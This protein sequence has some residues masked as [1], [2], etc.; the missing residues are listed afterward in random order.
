MLFGFVLV[1]FLWGT[2]TPFMRRSLLSKDKQ[3]SSASC[4][5]PWSLW[6]RLAALAT[7]W[8]FVVPYA[9][10]QCG[11]VLFYYLL[12]G[13]DMCLAVPAANTLSFLFTFLTEAAQR[14][15]KLNIRTH[16]NT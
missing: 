6:L 3:M 1:G 14:K 2:T 12:T 10:N 4:S 8:K 7:N 5:S 11:S 13:Y 9:L 16:I 15:T